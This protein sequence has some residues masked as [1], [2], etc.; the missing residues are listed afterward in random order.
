MLFKST[1]SAAA[2]ERGPHQNVIAYS[3]YGS[4]FSEPKFFDLYLKTFTETLRTI[5]LANVRSCQFD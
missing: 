1:C 3:M 2:D 4:N 5:E